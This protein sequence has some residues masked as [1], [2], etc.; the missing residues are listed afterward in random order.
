MVSLRIL[1]LGENWYGSCARA[2]SYA[3]RRMSYDV[4]DI[5]AQ[6]F[7]P[8]LRMPSSRSV[9]RLF[10]RR[11]VREY[12]QTIL[13]V[14]SAF[15]PDLLIAF[16]GNYVEAET[17]KSLRGR[18]V[19]LYNYYPDR[20]ALAGKRFIREVIPEYDC[21]FDTKRSW[22]NGL[23]NQV[24]LRARV[25][26]PHGYDPE[27]HRLMELQREDHLRYGCDVSLIATH[28]PRKEETL[29][30]LVTIR[31]DLKLRIWGN[32][33]VKNN[34]S[35]ELRK[36]FA[37]PALEGG[38]YAKA[39]SATRINLAIMGVRPGVE[40]E[41]TTRTYEIP[42]CGGFM[43]HERTD[44]VLELFEE[45]KEM[46]SFGSAGELAEKIDFYLAHPEERAAIAAAGHA[47]CVPAY[48]YDN[49]MAEIIRWHQKHREQS[50]RS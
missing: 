3:L 19:S 14:A 32:L 26:L 22:D 21:F 37:G 1:F 48:S 31:P 36:H 7:F 20:I 25:F 16:K 34:Q 33:W 28:S 43:L 11:L 13:K 17:L 50:A 18:G 44:E 41:T 49:R 27:V 42:A 38:L 40:D 39:L 10:G 23:E 47:R 29:R 9:L 5:D 2:C 4:L 6:T 30:Q 46:A 24:N 35:P 15:Q 45:G 12:N 8:Q